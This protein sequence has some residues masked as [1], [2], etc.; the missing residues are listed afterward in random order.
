MRV[1]GTN[2]EVC[3]EPAGWD[4]EELELSER[5]PLSRLLLIGSVHSDPDGFRRSIGWLR[6]FKPDLVLV[7]LSP[8]GLLFRKAHERC[9]QQTLLSNLEEAAE[10]CDIPFK[11]ALKH[12][13]IMSARRQ[14]SLPFEYRAA[15]E[16]ALHSR[17]TVRLVDDSSFS[18]K[19]IATWPEMISIENLVSLLSLPLRERSVQR[20]YRSAALRIRSEAISE[21]DM[22]MERGKWTEER[23]RKRERFMA[24]QIRKTLHERV[25]QKAVFLGGWW[26]L[27]TST[28][29]LTLRTILGLAPDHCYLL[30]ESLRVAYPEHQAEVPSRGSNRQAR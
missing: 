25:F 22:L 14:I 13:E 28:Q 15:S 2:R 18:R 26:H 23:W 20:A 12:P 29:A 19:W 3:D 4:T 27:T 17:A 1:S 10:T 5:E 9:F 16:Y 11:Q 21:L 24:D 8:F 30:D 7:E 6:F